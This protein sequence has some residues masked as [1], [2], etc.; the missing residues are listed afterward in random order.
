MPNGNL[1]KQNWP[2]GVIKVV[3]NLVLTQLGKKRGCVF[4]QSVVV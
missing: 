3:S 1:L 4:V 2:Y